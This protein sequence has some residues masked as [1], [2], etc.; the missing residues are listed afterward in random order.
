MRRDE[1]ELQQ[2]PPNDRPGDLWACGTKGDSPCS[3]GPDAKGRCPLVDSCHPE[4]T[5][6]GRQKQ[7]SM[8]AC[9]LAV[10]VVFLPLSK[11]ASVACHIQQAVKDKCT[12]CH[13]YH[14]DRITLRPR[15][16]HLE[17]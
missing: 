15:E 16:T 3:C 10:L 6:H 4:Q 14:V 7:V 8:I 13:R 9:G 17:R 5:W 12:T 11:Q 1:I 2:P